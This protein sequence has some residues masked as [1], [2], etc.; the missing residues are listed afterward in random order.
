[1]GKSRRVAE[2]V[3]QNYAEEWS[4]HIHG[5]LSTARVL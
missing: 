1:M 4:S 3:N 2:N 5:I